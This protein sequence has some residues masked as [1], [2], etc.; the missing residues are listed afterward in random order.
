M[1]SRELSEETGLSPATI[2]TATTQLEALGYLSASQPIGLRQGKA[3]VFAVKRDQF[4]GD[5]RTLDLW[6]GRERPL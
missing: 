2:Q 4:D 1:T 5:M 3:V 6:L